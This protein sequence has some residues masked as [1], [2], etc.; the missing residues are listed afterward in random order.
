MRLKSYS[1]TSISI[2]QDVPCRGCL[3]LCGLICGFDL[4]CIWIRTRMGKGKGS[5]NYMYSVLVC[6]LD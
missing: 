6:Q 1:I 4:V 5:Q 2:I 3:V